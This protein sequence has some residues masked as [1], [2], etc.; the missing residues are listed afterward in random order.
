MNEQEQALNKKKLNLIKSGFCKSSER[1]SFAARQIRRSLTR[2]E[3][4]LKRWWLANDD[5]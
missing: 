4:I 5:T 1:T 3:S 2:S